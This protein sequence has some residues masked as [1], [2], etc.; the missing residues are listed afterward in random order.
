MA[1]QGRQAAPSGLQGAADDRAES[2]PGLI[3]VRVDGVRSPVWAGGPASATSAVVFLHG[4]LGSVRDWT[5]LL[6]PVATFA[7]CIAP[8]MPGYAGADKPNR[9]D[10]TTEGYA[11]H[12]GGLLDQLSVREVHLVL[13]DL[14][15][16]WGLAWAAAH[17]KSLASLSL[18]NIGFLPDYS[19]HRYARIY[20]RPVLGELLLASATRA[21]ISLILREGNPRGVPRWLVD[22]TVRQCR[23]AGTRRAVLRF[24]RGTPDLG[25]VTE[26][27]APPIRDA[28]PP[29]LVIWGARDPYVP[30]RYAD[31]Q[32]R[33]LPRAEVVVLPDSGHWPFL[34][35]PGGVADVL[36]PFLR[37]QQR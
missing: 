4:A 32:R 3:D 17:P 35:D 21:G 15:G 33:Y 31:I 12:L 5:D 18:I 10:Y 22:E 37:A 13:H 30:V 36:I 26:R 23:D 7:R 19:W 25:L 2:A 20:R 24:Y 16:P 11:R 34:D 8:E 29:S 6:G 14:G 27:A 1:G 28:N 9:F